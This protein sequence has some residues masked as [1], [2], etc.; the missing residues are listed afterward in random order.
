MQRLSDIALIAQVVTLGSER[1]F[2]QL[3]RAHQEAVRRFLLRLTTGDEM[4]ADDLAQETFIRAWQ[5][6]SS[7][8]QLAGFETWLLRIAYRVFLDDER[9]EKAHPTFNPETSSNSPKGDPNTLSLEKGQEAMNDEGQTETFSLHYDLDQALST[10]SETERTCVVLQCVQGQSIREIAQIM[11][12]PENTVKSHLLRGKK[13]LAS[14]L[15]R[16]GYC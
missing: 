7:F 13:N 16:N 3:V 8:R 10:L 14:Y 15:R 9:K 12:L 5:G 1:A 6:L 11:S 4:R 2:G